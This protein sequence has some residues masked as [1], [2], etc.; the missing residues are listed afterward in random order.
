MYTENGEYYFDPIGLY[1]EKGTTVTFV[2]ESGAHTSTSY[3]ED[4]DAENRIPSGAETWD[5]GTLTEEDATF[6]HAFNT[7][8]TFD[9]FCIPHKSLEMIGR[10]V[11]G[12]PGGP[13]EGTMP[14]D[15][16]VPASEKIVSEKS[17]SYDSFQG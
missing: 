5:S 2:N 12:E 3:S 11:V 10:I 17:I 4:N 8:G 9:Y 16:T 14:P 13:A 1:V 7:T 15:G 6:D